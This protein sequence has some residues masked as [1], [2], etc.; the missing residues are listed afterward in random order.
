MAQGYVQY[1]THP[2]ISCS[3]HQVML[4]PAG[5]RPEAAAAVEHVARQAG[6]QRAAREISGERGVRAPVRHRSVQLTRRVFARR[7]SGGHSHG[8]D[9][10]AHRPD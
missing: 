4:Q 3:S 6:R 9:G 2:S 7:R 8:I 1:S 10:E 5:S